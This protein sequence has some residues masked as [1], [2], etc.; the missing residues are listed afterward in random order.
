MVTEINHGHEVLR[1]AI[2]N[3]DFERFRSLIADGADINGYDNDGITLLIDA[4]M[5][6]PKPDVAAIL[7]KAGADPGIGDRDEMATPL[8]WAVKSASCEN[9]YDQAKT[10]IELLIGAGADV[11]GRTES[12]AIALTYAVIHDQ[13]EIVELLLRAG[14][15]PNARTNTGWTALDYADGFGRVTGDTRKHLLASGATGKADTH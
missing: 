4:C 12:G 8:I 9:C 14:A 1:S 3:G 13:P 15:D 5:E 10:V 2:S 11:N 6:T 7:L